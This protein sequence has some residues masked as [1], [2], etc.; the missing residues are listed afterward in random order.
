MNKLSIKEFIENIS[1]PYPRGHDEGKCKWLAHQLY[2]KVIKK[3]LVVI[4][5]RSF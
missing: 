1:M 4:T 5:N 2:V 3:G